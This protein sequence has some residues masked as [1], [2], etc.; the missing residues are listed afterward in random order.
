MKW[1]H[2]IKLKFLKAFKLDDLF[3]DVNLF[4]EN[5]ELYDFNE[6]DNFKI[7]KN[8]K[9]MIVIDDNRSI[10]NII[11]KEA[12]KYLKNY[13]FLVFS[14]QMAAYNLIKYFEI[15]N[16]KPDIAYIDIFFNGL[17]KVDDYNLKLDGVDVLKYLKDKNK[18]LNYVFFTSSPLTPEST[19]INN[20]NKKFEV[21]EQKEIHTKCLTKITSDEEIRANIYK[22]LDLGIDICLKQNEI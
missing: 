12:K 22:E 18:D 2:R 7:D 4:V 3:Y 9:I 15:N 6:I 5:H 16:I 17:L 20:I 19:R 21:L 13:N 14:T 1:L 8:K 11:K 10:C